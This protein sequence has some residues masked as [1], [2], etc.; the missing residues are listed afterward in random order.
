[1]GF[2][3]AQHRLFIA[4]DPGKFVAFDTA[5][6]KS[7]ASLDIAEGADGVHYDAKRALIY[8]SCG[9]GCIEVIKQTDA[10]HYSKLENIATAKDAGTSL[11]V[12]EFARLFLLVP[13]I[14]KQDA[15]VR[16]FST[17]D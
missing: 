3:R 13:Q 12:P 14:E 1:M 17:E 10:D 9:A 6:G 4:C 15:E 11:F 8:I 5:S 16:A 2:D 7:V